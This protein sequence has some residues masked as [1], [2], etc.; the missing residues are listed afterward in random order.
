ML[1]YILL[2]MDMKI[3]WLL[4]NALDLWQMNNLEIDIKYQLIAYYVA[5]MN[6]C[7]I[8]KL[9]NFAKSVTVE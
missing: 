7:D 3:L 1:L 4:Q 8:D 5:K 2:D 9:K 6:E